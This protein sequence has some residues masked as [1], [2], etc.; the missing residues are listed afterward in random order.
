MG[1]LCEASLS[2]ETRCSDN[3]FEPIAEGTLRKSVRES[4]TD[5]QVLHVEDISYL[6]FVLEPSEV[7]QNRNLTKG[8]RKKECNESGRFQDCLLVCVW[9]DADA[10][11]STCIYNTEKLIPLWNGWIK[12]FN[13]PALFCL[14]EW[15]A[16]NPCP[17]VD[18]SS[19]PFHSWLQSSCA[20]VETRKTKHRDF[21]FSLGG[22][23]PNFGTSPPMWSR[24]HGAR[25]AI[26]TWSHHHFA[27]WLKRL[28]C[29]LED[30]GIP[31]CW[32]LKVWLRGA[33]C[34]T[35]TWQG[36]IRA[37]AEFISQTI[38]QSSHEMQRGWMD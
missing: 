23:V 18:C 10:F 2:D 34:I 22:R 15:I 28:N 19:V 36:S 1:W 16:V 13:P 26:E 20:R 38:L 24:L 31:T 30:V 17:G 11:D 35:W 29:L 5:S 32:V 25:S 3:T 6:L 14:G 12:I 8:N 21:C 27:N 7:S 33:H 4:E 9:M 37:E